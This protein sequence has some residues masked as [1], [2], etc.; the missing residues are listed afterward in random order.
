MASL[1][2]GSMLTD[3]GFCAQCKE[4]SECDHDTVEVFDSR[5]S[6]EVWGAPKSIGGV[7]LWCSDCGEDVTSL[8]TEMEI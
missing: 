1:C 8:K 4:P 7:S 6:V 2:C 3:A 5:Q